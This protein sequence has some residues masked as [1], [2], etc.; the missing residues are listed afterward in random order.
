MTRWSREGHREALR[1]AGFH[2]AALDGTPYRE[3]DMPPAAA[4]PADGFETREA[5]VQRNREL[6]T[7]LAVGVVPRSPRPPLRFVSSTRQVRGDAFPGPPR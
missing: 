5:M 4:I 3:V 7:L 2:V 1:A 6:G